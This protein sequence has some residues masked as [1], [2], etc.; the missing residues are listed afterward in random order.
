MAQKQQSI[1]LKNL[2]SEALI[3]TKKRA[4][5]LVIQAIGDRPL[6]A[7]FQNESYSEYPRAFTNGLLIF[8]IATVMGAWALSGLRIFVEAFSESVN[9]LPEG[10]KVAAAF[11]GLIAVFLSESAVLAALLSRQILFSAEQRTARRTLSLIAVFATT[12]A[13]SANIAV[14]QAHVKLAVI[15]F[16]N[17]PS[18]LFVALEASLPL[19]VI[20][21]STALE[22]LFLKQIRERQGAIRRWNT[23]LQ[24][25]QKAA[26]D[27]TAH[28]DYE[29]YLLSEVYQ[30]WLA[31]NG[32]GNGQKSR[33][34]TIN[35]LPDDQLEKIIR[36][37]LAANPFN[38][39]GSVNVNSEPSAQV[40]QGEGDF[41][42]QRDT[43]AVAHPN[44][45]GAKVTPFGG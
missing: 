41:L 16:Q 43:L 38:R 6:L 37:Q 45:N 14:T 3:A 26:H 39:S 9:S 40:E 29:Y 22:Q 36:S 23:A 42:S 2:P 15:N 1:E 28:P 20:G 21:L 10:G 5:A 44:G 12:L 32:Q 17:A 30:K 18:T 24:E 35:A 4:A 19:I 34:E 33:L 8:L 25:W 27:P 7:Q 31:V 11:S 13:I